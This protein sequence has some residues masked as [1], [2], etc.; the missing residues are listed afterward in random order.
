MDGWMVK[1][2]YK[3]VVFGPMSYLSLML[4]MDTIFGETP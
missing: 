2:M 4:A 3:L 1:L